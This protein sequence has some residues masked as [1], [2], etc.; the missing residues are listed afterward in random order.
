MGAAEKLESNVQHVSFQGS[1]EPPG[2]GET[3]TPLRISGQ[4]KV[5]ILESH[6]QVSG[7]HSKSNTGQVLLFLGALGGVVGALTFLKMKFFPDLPSWV[8]GAIGGGLGVGLIQLNK[9]KGEHESKPLNLSLKPENIKKVHQ[10]KSGTQYENFVFIDV[11]KT[12]PKGRIY[13]NPKDMQ[14]VTVTEAIEQFL[15][16]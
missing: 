3:A 4:G 16:K 15:K 10:G 6:I 13:F 9:G 8:T 2:I 14:A 11:K 5:E 1:F 7:F 12:K